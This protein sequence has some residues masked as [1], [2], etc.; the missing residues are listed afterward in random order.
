[1][2]HTLRRSRSKY[3]YGRTRR[4]QYRKQ[5]RMRG[6]GIFD[7]IISKF[8]PSSQQEKCSKARE[9]A[10]NACDNANAEGA[11]GDIEMMPMS[12]DNSELNSGSGS[13]SAKPA[14]PTIDTTITTQLPPL[15]EEPPIPMPISA[16]AIDEGAASEMVPNS[17]DMGA[18]KAR[19]PIQQ[20]P[21]APLYQ[22]QTDNFGGAKTSKRKNKNKKQIRRKQIKS[23]RRHKK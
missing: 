7:E 4:Q 18:E 20:P 16:I 2:T 21:A 11:E 15:N 3:K 22:P 13:G 23:S 6:G 19:Y 14:I 12:M 9:A 17:S 8:K 1:M 10:R 5:R